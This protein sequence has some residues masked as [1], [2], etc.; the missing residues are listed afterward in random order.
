[1]IKTIVGDKDL[2]YR[3]VIQRNYVYLFELE[4]LFSIYYYLLTNAPQFASVLCYGY[5]CS[6]I[7]NFSKAHTTCR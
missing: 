5:C 7:C 3:Y 6:F 1:M 2:F 4:L